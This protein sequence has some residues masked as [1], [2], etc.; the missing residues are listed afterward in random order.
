[1]EFNVLKDGA[2]KRRG[3]WRIFAHPASAIHGV[4]SMDKEEDTREYQ[5][6]VNS[7]EQY[8]LWL[9]GQAMGGES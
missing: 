6:L 4:V 3:A 5:V 1:M 2:T 8:S 7:E 9:A